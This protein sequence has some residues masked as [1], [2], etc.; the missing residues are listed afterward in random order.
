MARH[1]A[2]L[3][4]AACVDMAPGTSGIVGTSGDVTTAPG[5]YLGYRVA[6][7]CDVRSA[8]L[9]VIGTGPIELTGSALRS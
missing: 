3:V 6:A 4:L 7:P 1:A 5:D 2:L 9:G 8:N